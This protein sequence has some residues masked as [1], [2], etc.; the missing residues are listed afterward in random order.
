[1]V[2][3]RKRGGK[4]KKINLLALMFTV[5]F[6]IA[7]QAVTLDAKETKINNWHRLGSDNLFITP[8]EATEINKSCGALDK[9]FSDN[10]LY[11][12]LVNES[13]QEINYDTMQPFKSDQ[14]TDVYWDTGAQ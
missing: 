3:L 2:Y 6:T 4:M 11:V 9:L 8:E 5:V 10:N 13:T 14:I 1:M 7:G 12:A